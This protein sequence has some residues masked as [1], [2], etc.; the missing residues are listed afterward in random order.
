MSLN[1][2]GDSSVPRLQARRFHLTYK[3]HISIEDYPHIKDASKWSFVHETSDKETP[4]DHTHILLWYEKPKHVN[5]NHFDFEGVHPNIQ[6]VK[7]NAHWR[8]TVEYHKKEPVFLKTEN[9]ET[10]V[11]EDHHK[12]MIKDLIEGKTDIEL[13]QEYGGM[14]LRSANALKHLRC[15]TFKD[16]KE[17]PKVIWAYGPSGYG[18]TRWAHDNYKDDLYVK[19]PSNHWWDGYKQQKC[20]LLDDYDGSLYKYKA[21]LQLLDRYP[22]RVEIKGGSMPF[23]SEVIY[24]TS[25]QSPLD[26]YTMSDWQLVRRITEIRHFIEE[27]KYEIISYTREQIDEIIKNRNKAESFVV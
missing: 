27:N 3:G 8:N 1:I 10:T 25:S 17:A 5:T 11:K 15:E 12:A 2:K 14:Y 4:Y 9:V 23:N 7:T 20:V 21:L 6:I 19:M 22:H 18:K 26:I 13:A 16:R 24:I